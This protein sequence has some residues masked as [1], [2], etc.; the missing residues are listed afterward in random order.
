MKPRYM[1]LRW[2]RRSIMR[3]SSKGW[4]KRLRY[5]SSHRRGISGDM[6]MVLSFLAA[7]GR[8][9]GGGQREWACG[10]KMHRV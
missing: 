7:D 3:E 9:S 8:P 1:N 5:G 6:T 4:P 10:I 2:L